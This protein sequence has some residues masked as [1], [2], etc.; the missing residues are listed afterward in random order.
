MTLWEQA[1][2]PGGLLRH[3][4]SLPVLHLRD[5]AAYGEY[6]LRALTALG[7]ELRLGTRVTAELLRTVEGETVVLATGAPPVLT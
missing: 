5:L 2:A 1:P 6:V 3:V 7:V 4:A